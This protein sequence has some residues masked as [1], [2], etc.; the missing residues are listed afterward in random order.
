M[1]FEDDLHRLAQHLAALLTAPGRVDDGELAMV[2][3]AR[4]TIRQLCQEILHDLTSATP[5]GDSPRAELASRSVA[6]LRRVLRHELV[7]YAGP[8]GP[9]TGWMDLSATSQAGRHWR[10]ARRHAYLATHEWEMIYPAG[11]PTNGGA[12]P[13][14]LDIAAIA[15]ATAHAERDL[16]HGQPLATSADILTAADDHA[17]ALTFA[18]EQ[19][20]RIAPPTA[21]P[22]MHPLPS[23]RR[24]MVLRIRSS[25]DAPAGIARL[26]F[27]LRAA[28]HLTPE[29]VRAIAR[30]H[31]HTL[32]TIARHL[33][34]NTAATSRDA[35][36][37]DGL[38]ELI[39]DLQQLTYD[40]R[41]LRSLEP[42]DPRPVHQARLIRDSWRG[43]R[44][45]DATRRDL[46]AAAA[47]S[48]RPALDAVTALAEVIDVHVAAGTWC[49]HRPGLRLPWQPTNPSI[50]L[51]ITATTHRAVDHVDQVARLLPPPAV[52]DRSPH[53]ALL[54]PLR[55]RDIRATEAR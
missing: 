32:L 18:A 47:R 22:S 49:H 36:I 39:N 48:L 1:T 9:S 33:T 24:H 27:L 28:H 37:A 15:E 43:A 29:A 38:R 42:G 13:H 52:A 3:A 12:W 55:E 7:R 41:R 21:P 2:D 23:R 40:T 46:D 53:A 14:I 51:G 11:R 17:W 25:A 26:T 10:D 8:E 5:I 20:R 34:K 35:S 19:V 31:A 44:R 30:G 4:A 45:S 50:E 54:R 6:A 16:V